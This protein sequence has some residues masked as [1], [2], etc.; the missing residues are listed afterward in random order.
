MSDTITLDVKLRDTLGKQVKQI[1]R[2]GLV[3]GV[4]H[5]F[6][7]DS[8]HVQ[9]DYT[10]VARV[11]KDAG[12]HHPV[13]LSLDGTKSTVMI[14]K[15]DRDPK[16]GTITHFVLESVKANEVVEASVP[17][18]AAFAE[19]NEASPAERAGLIVLDQLTEA[20]V[21]AFPRNL[22][23][24][25]TYDAEKLVAVGDQL[26][27]ADLHMPE[28]VELV[29]EQTQVI[30]TVFEPSALAAANDDAGG[31]ADEAT[32]VD[33]DNGSDGAQ[34]EADTSQTSGAKDGK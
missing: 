1:R 28:N 20:V 22:P 24:Q 9:T 6:G 33:A 12:R 19:G 14:R 13:E 2:H 32:T 8:S 10:A 21:K 7:K 30:V 27:A 31:D 3:P 17:I 26:T 25:L 23:N 18:V 4:V 34:P 5:N 29:T 15:I 16:T 11:V